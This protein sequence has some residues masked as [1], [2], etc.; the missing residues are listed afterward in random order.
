[1]SYQSATNRIG[2]CQV[3]R[4]RAELHN[5]AGKVM[6][7]GCVEKQSAPHAPHAPNNGT[8]DNHTD[9]FPTHKG[10][11]ICINGRRY[12]LTLEKKVKC[13]HKVL[14]WLNAGP[15]EY[16]FC[17]NC[18]AQVI[19]HERNTTSEESHQVAEGSGTDDDIPED[20]RPQ[21]ADKGLAG[22]HGSDEQPAM[23]NRIKAP[24]RK[25]RANKA[26]DVLAGPTKV[27]GIKSASSEEPE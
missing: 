14:D 2:S 22:L 17:P 1:M 26:P 13:K 9:E 19:F 10:D 15:V 21:D 4:E 24:K 23:G 16:S 5:F 20:P 8:S 3:C 11:Y 6:C 25:K 18:G 7:M 27:F 12:K